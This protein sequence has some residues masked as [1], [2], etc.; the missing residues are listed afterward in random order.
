MRMGQANDVYE[1]IKLQSFLKVFEGFD[2]VTVNGVYDS[3]TAQAVSAFQ[4]KYSNEV[5]APWGIN[6]P[7]GYAYITT[8]GKINQIICGSGIPAVSPAPTKVFHKE[9]GISKEGDFKEG[10]GSTTLNSIPVVGQDVMPSSGTTAKGHSMAGAGDDP[11]GLAAAL[12]SWPT[13]ARDTMQCL[14]E[15]LLILI[16]LYILGNVLESVL[17][18]DTPEN[19]LKRFYTKWT[20]IT[21]GLALSFLGAYMLKEWCLLLPLVIA[22]LASLAWMLTHSKHDKFKASATALYATSSSKARSMMR[23]AKE[24]TRTERTDL[25]IPTEEKK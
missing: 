5:L 19:V 7:T 11:N 1:V 18:K 22:F 23:G 14:Y 9:G 10:M 25:M 2:Y 3:A 13:T 20:T 4:L 17:Y 15:L 8:V 21:V 6:A 16:V 24:I 12:I